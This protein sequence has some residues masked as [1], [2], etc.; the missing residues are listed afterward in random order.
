MPYCQNC[1][2]EIKEGA[3]F[4]ATCGKP[5]DKELTEQQQTQP[6]SLP[7]VAKKRKKNKNW[8]GYSIAV[9][10]VLS[11]VVLIVLSIDIPKDPGFTYIKKNLLLD[12]NSAEL[13]GKIEG[14]EGNVFVHLYGDKY[15]G[16]EFGGKCNRG[17][18]YRIRAKNSFGG[19]VEQDF[20]V[21]WKNGKICGAATIDNLTS[22]GTSNMGSLFFA[23]HEE[24]QCTE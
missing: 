1:G 13:I 7:T 21:V 10:L 12:P 6:T 17:D 24:C 11:I 3:K 23:L 19:Y 4:C 2:T 16:V 20:L 14:K 15:T 22:A 5:I 8:L 18:T 9:V